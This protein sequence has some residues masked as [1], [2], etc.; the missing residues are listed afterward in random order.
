MSSY[1]HRES[2]KKEEN[3]VAENTAK[4]ISLAFSITR[5]KKVLGD[6]YFWCYFHLAF[7]PLLPYGS[8]Q[9]QEHTLGK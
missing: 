1:E 3:E 5:S 2:T 9:C 8:Y 6:I 7:L 4:I